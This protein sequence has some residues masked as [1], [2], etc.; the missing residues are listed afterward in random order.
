MEIIFLGTS[1]M[2]PTKERNHQ[3]IFIPYK[4]EGLLLD[5]GEGTQRQL[6]IAEIKPTKITKLLITHWHG[7]HVLG[8]P[9]LLQTLNASEYEKKLEIFGPVGTIEYFEHMFRAFSFRINFAHSIT[10][11]KDGDRLDFK[12]LVVETHD[13]SH[14]IPCLGYSICEKDRRRIRLPY[15]KK[16]GIPEGPLLGDLQDNKSI[17]WKGEKISPDDATYVVAGKK[18]TIILDS[19]LCNNAYL[20]AKDSDLLV[21][22]AVYAS[23]LLHKAEEYKHMT[24]KQAA[25]LAAASNA[26]KLILTH[27]SQRY[28]SVEELLDEAKIIFKNTSAA[29]DFMKVKV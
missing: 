17:N 8:L 10:E 9:G 3:A 21:C 23:S 20:L 7:D 15:I 24:A 11:I 4:E 2:V 16:K 1:C 19:M 26:K 27:F 12:D 22:E 18:T 6:K 5:C 28:K 25:E 13:L 29:F 14:I